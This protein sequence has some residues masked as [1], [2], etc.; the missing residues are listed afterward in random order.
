MK[1]CLDFLPKCVK[2]M[3][4]INNAASCLLHGFCAWSSHKQGPR[5]VNVE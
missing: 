1:N 5:W 2:I 3:I 4:V